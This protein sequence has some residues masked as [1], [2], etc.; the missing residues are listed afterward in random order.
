MDPAPVMQVQLLPVFARSAF[1]SNMRPLLVLRTSTTCLSSAK[2]RAQ[3]VAAWLWLKSICLADQKNQARLQGWGPR[4]RD[5]SAC[6]QRRGETHVVCPGSDHRMARTVSQVLTDRAHARRAGDEQ[7]SA[8]D[9][10]L[11]FF[12]LRPVAYLGERDG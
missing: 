12:G 2:P 11:N 3:A 4:L 6:L 1:Y 7:F 10:S 8:E 9:N 5:D